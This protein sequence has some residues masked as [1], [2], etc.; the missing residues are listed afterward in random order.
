V[1]DNIT[2]VQHGNIY[3]EEYV[4]KF[5]AA[6]NFNEE[7]GKQLKTAKLK[8]SYPTNEVSLSRQL[9]QVAR[10]IA[11]RGERGAERDVFYVEIGGW[12]THASVSQELN[13]RFGELNAALETFVSEM[14]AQG[15]FD[16]TTL[17][18][19]SDFA[20]TL[21]PNSG[22]GT[23]HGWA[24]NHVII[25]GAVKGGRVYNDFPSSYQEGSD[26][27]AGRGRLIPKHPWENMMM[28]VAEWM[29][30]ENSQLPSVFPNIAAFNSSLLMTGS[31][32]FVAS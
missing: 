11:A 5:S 20:R 26:Q 29:G 25:G 22:D 1:I 28:P 23:D 4:R 12:D 14:K 9:K 24:G 19:H 3:A 32:L 27:D 21:T 8:T 6:I 7:L 17:L 10:L 31:T 2:S 16:S 15:I 18:T 30:V 13:N